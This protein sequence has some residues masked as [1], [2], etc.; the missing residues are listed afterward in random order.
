MAVQVLTDQEF[1]PA[2]SDNDK[3]IVKYYGRLVRFL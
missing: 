2:L 3:V 1:Q